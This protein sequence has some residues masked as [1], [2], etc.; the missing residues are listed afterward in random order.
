MPLYMH[1]IHTIYQYKCVGV[2]VYAP[3]KVNV[4]DV[5]ANSLYERA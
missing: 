5:L 1:T 2:R 4:G 3:L